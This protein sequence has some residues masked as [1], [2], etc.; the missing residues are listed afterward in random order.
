MPTTGDLCVPF[1]KSWMNN[2]TGEHSNGFKRDLIALLLNTDQN[3]PQPRGGSGGSEN[4]FML[5]QGARHV[6]KAIGWDTSAALS[7]I[8]ERG[9]A[10]VNQRLEHWRDEDG[11]WGTEQMSPIYW[12]FQ[13]LGHVAMYNHTKNLALKENLVKS[14]SS[15]LFYSK[16]TYMGRDLINPGMRGNGWSN[17]VDRGLKYVVDRSNPL[18]EYLSH[19]KSRV[20]DPFLSECS[21]V[22]RTM[23]APWGL[24]EPY[25]IAYV[26]NDPVVSWIETDR[27]GNTPARM[28]VRHKPLA[29]L[30]NNF[31]VEQR[32][33][34]T[35]QWIDSVV[36]NGNLTLK[37][38]GLYESLKDYEKSEN[39]WSWKDVPFTVDT[40]DMTGRHR[41]E[42]PVDA[43][44]GTQEPPKD[45][46]PTNPTPTKKE[47]PSWI[48][49]MGL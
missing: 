27:N 16:L 33:K 38:R 5:K 18:P 36:T 25:H 44:N 34:G 48:E 29:I 8:I 6:A 46:T 2:K 15:F 26:Y 49:R 47:K 3:E 42:Y 31:H 30:P 24:K 41:V 32:Q 37:Y 19:L 7:K 43:Q 35:N 23:L 17:P 28:A 40:W 10:V 21:L 12:G 9:D 22:A 45:P 4:L 20:A 13:F 1:I 14:F 11:L 39:E